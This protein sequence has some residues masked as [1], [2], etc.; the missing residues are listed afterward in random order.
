MEENNLIGRRIRELRKEERLT[1]K[2][3][4][5]RMG[6]SVTYLSEVERGEARANEKIFTGVYREFG[7]GVRQ[8]FFQPGNERFLPCSGREPGR[9]CLPV[10]LAEE[11]NARRCAGR[12]KESATGER[13]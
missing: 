12:V 6:I 4:S 8:D 5:E 7:V 10:G 3:L 9:F 13:K 11:K 1:L 2:E